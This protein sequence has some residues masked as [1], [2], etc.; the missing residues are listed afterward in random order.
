MD[1]KERTPLYRVEGGVAWLTLNRPETLNSFTTDFVHEIND[2]IRR[3]DEDEA[4]RARRDRR[5]TRLQLRRQPL[6]AGG[7]EPRPKARH[8]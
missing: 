2:A 4:V 5:G 6:R 8:L 7:D 3:A 1:E